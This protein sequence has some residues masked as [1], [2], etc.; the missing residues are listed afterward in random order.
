MQEDTFV[1]LS[2]DLLAHPRSEKGSLEISHRP[3]ALSPFYT[4]VPSH[5]KKEEFR[6]EDNTAP[7]C[8]LCR[9]IPCSK[10]V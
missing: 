10:T 5:G 4:P 6:T 8:N 1:R 9:A 7:L 2:N 3:M